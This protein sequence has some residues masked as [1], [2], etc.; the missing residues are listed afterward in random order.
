MSVPQT[1]WHT[2]DNSF[3]PNLQLPTPKGI[4]GAAFFL[5]VGSWEL[6]VALHG[7]I[8]RRRPALTLRIV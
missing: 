4:G 2:G 7:Y 3:N 8:A 5:W 1:M 6:G